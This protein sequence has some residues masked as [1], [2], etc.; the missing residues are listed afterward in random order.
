MKLFYWGEEASDVESHSEEESECNV[1]DSTQESGEL[2]SLVF[3][4][5]LEEVCVLVCTVHL[6]C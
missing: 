6:T 3:G 5:T 4:T 1:E 2:E